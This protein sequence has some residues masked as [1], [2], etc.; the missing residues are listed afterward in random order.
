MNPKEKK[1]IES[2]IW[3][4]KRTKWKKDRPNNQVRTRS[5]NIIK[6]LPGTKGEARNVRSEIECLKL[7]INDTVLGIITVSTNIYIDQIRHKFE[8]CRDAR[9][10]N[11]KEIAMSENRFRFLIRC[12]RFDDVRTRA[13]RREL[14][15]LAPIRELFENFLANFQ[16]H[17]IASEYLTVD[18]QLLAFRGRCAFKQYIPSKPA[19]YGIKVFALVDA[20][21]SYTF[22]LEPYVGTQPEGGP[23]RLSN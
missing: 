9:Q 2:S 19:K 15:K 20:K 3:E 13:E 16:N 21:T 22:N 10:T 23:Y 17:F 18:E 6:L 8:R 1:N 14:E 4:K 5:L 12:L 7:F 11:K